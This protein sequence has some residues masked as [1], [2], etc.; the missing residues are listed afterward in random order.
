M[1]DEP[2]QKQVEVPAEPP[3]LA[4]LRKTIRAMQVLYFVLFGTS[5][6]LLVTSFG[7]HSKTQ[8]LLWALTL[9]GA[10][11]TRLVRTSFVNKYNRLVAGG[12]PAPLS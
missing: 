1:A 12:R 9:G 5:L 6:V 10:V 2:L 3:T 11:L 7:V 8:N 4:R